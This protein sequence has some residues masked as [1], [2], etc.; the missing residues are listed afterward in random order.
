MLTQ[1]QRFLAALG[2]LAACANGCHWSAAGRNVTGTAMYQQGRY[3]EA[4]ANF[5]QALKDEPANADAYYNMASSYHNLGK[6]QGDQ[7]ALT[8][9]EQLYNQCLNIS[10]DH[11]DCHRALACLLVETGRADKAFTLLE[12]WAQR[13]P[14]VVDS[15][16][17]VARLYQEFGDQQ[18]AIRHLEQAVNVDPNNPRTARAWAALANLRE[19]TGNVQQ[20]LM[21]YHRSHQ[22]NP[23]QPAVGERIAA[24][25]QSI[26]AA[27][28][29]TSSSTRTVSLPF[30][31][32][33]F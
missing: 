15:H 29:V 18:S 28:A 30:G 2:F 8:Q 7:A 17:E 13:S 24:L 26:G 25:Q 6:V 12:R 22:L 19:Q 14:N 5:E 32:T 16:I 3:H 20:A 27:P 10:P 23:F 11:P 31:P 21:D 9:A 33:R 1:Q 4:I